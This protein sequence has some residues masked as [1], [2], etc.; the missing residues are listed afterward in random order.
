[1]DQSFVD[2]NGVLCQPGDEVT[3]FGYD[4]GGNLL[5]SQYLASLIGA[6]EGCG[7]TSAL[8]ERVE[9]RYLQRA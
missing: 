1:M 2:L 6:Y 7:L 9:R 3:L 5:S 4:A 8:T